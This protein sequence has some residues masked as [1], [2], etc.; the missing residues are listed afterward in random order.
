MNK[1][2]DNND[3]GRDGKR[4]DDLGR[5]GGLHRISCNINFLGEKLSERVHIDYGPLA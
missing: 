2:C 5:A 3:D 1:R 4:S